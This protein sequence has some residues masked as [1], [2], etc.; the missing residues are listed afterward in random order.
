MNENLIETVL[1]EMTATYNLNETE[2][3]V[4]KVAMQSLAFKMR[5]GK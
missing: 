4:A 3:L 2:I 5:F 1:A